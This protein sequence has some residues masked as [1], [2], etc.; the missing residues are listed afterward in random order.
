MNY[1]DQESRMNMVLVAY[2][3]P[4]LPDN[5]YGMSVRYCKGVPIEFYDVVNKFIDRTKYMVIFRGPRATRWANNTLKEDAVA[6]DI[7]RFSH[8]KVKE[9]RIE[10]EAF[11]RGVKWAQ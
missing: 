1:Y 3:Q 5:Q 2:L 11:H 9:N 4:N 7:Y 6:F 8:T 10:R